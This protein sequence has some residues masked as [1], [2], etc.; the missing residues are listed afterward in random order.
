[1]LKTVVY[2]VNQGV[3]LLTA[4]LLGS[5]AVEMVDRKDWDLLSASCSSSM[6]FLILS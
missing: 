2:L 4:S 3:V 5:T 6:S 1:M